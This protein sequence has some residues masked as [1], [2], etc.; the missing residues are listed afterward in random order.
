MYED[1]IWVRCY[2]CGFETKEEYTFTCERCGK[3][4]CYVC[5]RDTGYVDLDYWNI[6][7]GYICEKCVPVHI[8]EVE[9]PMRI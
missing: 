8:T 1:G 2:D 5:W 9:C 4:F 6:G 3:T 7:S